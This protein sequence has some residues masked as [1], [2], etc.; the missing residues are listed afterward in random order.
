[1]NHELG[2]F[3]VV[4]LPNSSKAPEAPKLATGR[5]CLA[6]EQVQW[7]IF[8]PQCP[9]FR[10]LGFSFIAREGDTR[11]KLRLVEYGMAFGILV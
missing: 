1:M 2:V 3:V 4:C 7:V 6:E 8:C 9:Q 11:P 10:L 5:Y